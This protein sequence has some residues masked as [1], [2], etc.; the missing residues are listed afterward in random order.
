MNRL[1]RIGF[2]ILITS[3]TP[4][5]SWFVIGLI[6]DKQLTNVFSLTYPLQCLMGVIVSIFGIGANISA[7]KDNI[8]NGADN[9]IVYGTLLSIVIF[10]FIALNASQYI[11]YMNMDKSI[12]LI[13]CI[14]STLQILLQIIVEL[15]ITKLYYL[16]LNNKANKITFLFNFLNF[17]IL[18][19]MSLIT[20]NQVLIS[21]ITL[22]ILLIFDIILLFKNVTN[23][24][25]KL[26][27][28]NCI[29]YDIVSLSVYIMFFIIYLFG[30]SNSFLYGEKYIE[31]I[32][33][34]TIITD[35][36][37][38]MTNAIE[39]VAKI[40]IAKNK[41]DYNYH[42]K[43]AIYYTCLL[44]LS[45]ILMFIV[46]YPIYKPE[47]RIVS[48]FILL[49]IFNFLLIPFTSIKKCYLEIE[50]SPIK[51]A[52]NTIIAYIM[53]FIISLIASPFCTIIG[54]IFSAIYEF[55]Y[56]SIIARKFELFTKSKVNNKG[57]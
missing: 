39:N 20:K 28:K 23:F 40:D 50:Y 2:D 56:V 4:I 41:F 14:Y 13:F 32:T 9:G 1:F 15:V 48:I 36:Q 53:R 17:I 21:S 12:Y 24:D 10:C 47:I 19:I 26:N 46:I 16:D 5:L 3:L 52:T 51:T 6:I 8:T 43:N 49:H 42:L 30:F 22:I 29:K 31:A 33:F 35:I 38:D 25:F 11:T 44:I 27:F 54:Q 45:V 7:I 57:I 37:W 34:A 55:I 18:V